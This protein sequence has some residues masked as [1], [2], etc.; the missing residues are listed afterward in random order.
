MD[1]FLFDFSGVQFHYTM[2]QLLFIF[3]IVS[4]FLRFPDIQHGNRR[5][6]QSHT[7]D[8]QRRQCFRKEDDTNGSSHKGLNRRKDRGL[9]CLNMF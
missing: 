2:N 4:V 7:D 8:F 5:K 9:S 1:Y 6:Y 3:Y